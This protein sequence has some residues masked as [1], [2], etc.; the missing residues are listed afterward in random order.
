MRRPVTACT[1][2]GGVVDVGRLRR[3][4]LVAV[5]ALG[6]GCAIVNP[7]PGASMPAPNFQV[8]VDIGIF[9]GPPDPVPPHHF[10]DLGE[11]RLLVVVDRQAFQ[12]L[13]EVRWSGT[14][15][16]VVAGTDANLI[17]PGEDGPYLRTVTLG[18]DTGFSL[19]AIVLVA[20]VPNGPIGRVELEIDGAVEDVPISQRPIFARV[21][22]AGT[23]FGSEFTAFDAGTHE[24]DRGRVHQE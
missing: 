4:T 22:P 16:E 14:E 11:G 17:P 10:I 15:W 13:R 19:D 3:T 8:L 1:Y 12:S 23:E 24:L 21:Y 7:V 18:T 6:T 20:R 9:D 2:R 5:L